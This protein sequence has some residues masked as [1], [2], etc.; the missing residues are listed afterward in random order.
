MELA[1]DGRLGGAGKMGE[2]EREGETDRGREGERGR[3][4]GREGREHGRG[5]KKIFSVMSTRAQAGMLDYIYMPS[6]L[7]NSICPIFETIS[8]GGAKVLGFRV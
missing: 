8:G 6:L 4:R 1:G 2:K 7:D 3:G 5:L